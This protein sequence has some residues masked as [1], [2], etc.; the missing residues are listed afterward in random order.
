MGQLFATTLV[1]QPRVCAALIGILT[2]GLGSDHLLGYNA[3]W[4]GSPQWQIEG[5]AVSNPETCKRSTASVRSARWRRSK[6]DFSAATTR[7]SYGIQLRRAMPDIKGDRYTDQAERWNLRYGSGSK[8]PVDQS[9][10]A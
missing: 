9:V 5:C 3:L 6:I 10:F 1:A 2:K 8:G 7:S 4:T